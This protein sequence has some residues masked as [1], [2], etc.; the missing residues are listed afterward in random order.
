MSERIKELVEQ[1]TTIHHG[2]IV[3]FDKEK[4]AELIVSD[5]IL[6]IQKDVIRNGNT[7]ENQRTTTHLMA[8]R[9]H[10]GYDNSIFETWK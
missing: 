5:C 8:I 10:F 7:P 9:D 2:V 3:D 4:F 6:V 1:A